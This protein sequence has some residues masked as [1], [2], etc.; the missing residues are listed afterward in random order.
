MI[1]GSI[2]RRR[3]RT[4]LTVCAQ[5]DFGMHPI[6]VLLQEHVI[7]PGH[8]VKNAGVLLQL[9]MHTPLTHYE[10]ERT[11]NLSGLGHPQSFQLAVLVC[12]LSPVNHKGLHQGWTQTSLGLQV[13]HFTSHFHHKSCFLRLFIF[14][15]H[16]TREPV[17]N[18]VT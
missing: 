14:R 5:S 9:N 1:V 15:G 18:R 10:N 4:V 3:D 2:S 17:A 12:A 7:D 8:S 11:C 16:S 6:P 13:I